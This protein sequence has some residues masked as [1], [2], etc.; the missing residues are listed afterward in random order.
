MSSTPD[1]FPV[2]IDAP[3]SSQ[4][5]LNYTS[6]DDAY[7]PI[8]NECKN[9][10]ANI[11]NAE[12]NAIARH[13]TFEMK[14]QERVAKMALL[15]SLRSQMEQVTNEIEEIDEQL[16]ILQHSVNVAI[17]RVERAKKEALEYAYL[18]FNRSCR[19]VALKTNT[20]IM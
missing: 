2:G 5:P 6:L 14:K 16:P 17:E 10:T 4:S 3:N 15:S 7:Q 9:A 8:T 18:H 20:L 12:E 11:K 13:A 1:A 19:Y